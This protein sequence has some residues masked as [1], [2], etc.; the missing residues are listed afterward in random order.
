MSM[1]RWVGVWGCEWRGGCERCFFSRE[2]ERH[3]KN[4]TSTLIRCLNT[5]YVFCREL[6]TRIDFFFVVKFSKKFTGIFHRCPKNFGN[7]HASASKFPRITFYRNA[8]FR[9]LQT[10]VFYPN[11][12][13]S[14]CKNF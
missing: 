13:I 4:Q 9:E 5:F 7:L 3:V 11:K 6:F 12:N 10:S 2:I 8:N 14:F 1:Y